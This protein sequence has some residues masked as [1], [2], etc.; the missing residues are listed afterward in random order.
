[1]TLIEEFHDVYPRLLND[2]LTGPWSEVNA[3]TGVEIKM[4]PGPESFKLDLTDQRLPVCGSRKLFPRTAAAEVAWFVKGERSVAWLATYAA[5]WKKFVED[6]GDTILAAYGYRWRRHF[7]RDQLAGAVQALRDDP[8]NRRVYVSAW[9]PAGD[10]LTEKGQRNVPCPVG[11]TL[12]VVDGLL[13]S[14]MLLRSSDVFVGLPYD[15]MGHAMLMAVCAASI[16]LRGL[17]TMHVTMAH[18]HLYAKHYDMAREALGQ[19]RVIDKPE[20]LS[21]NIGA[22]EKDPDGFVWAYSKLAK[23]CEWP[24]FSPR[25]EVVQ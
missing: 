13:H 2:L 10:G 3:R 9:D 17:G 16:G 23:D 18:P 12:S 21:W 25:P 4:L 11:F 22:V 8:T 19:R 7:G 1:M 20:L 6:D 15:V 5:I 24:A 14:A